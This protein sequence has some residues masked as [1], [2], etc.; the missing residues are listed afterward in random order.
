MADKS[1]TYRMGVDGKESVEAAFRD[2]ATTAETAMAKTAAAADAATAGVERLSSRQSRALDTLIG[3][4]SP[5]ENEAGKLERAL[6]LLAKG[7]AAGAISLEDQAR[8]AELAEQKWS[9]GAKAA[10]AEAAA[11]G[12]FRDALDPAAAELARLGAEQQK[13]NAWLADGKITAAEHAAGVAGLQAQMARLTAQTVA[14]NSDRPWWVDGNIMRNWVDVGQVLAASGGN[15][16]SALPAI[17]D[18][19]DVTAYY[20]GQSR[21]AA[22]G[23]G[24][25]GSAMA[26]AGDDAADAAV[27]LEELAAGTELAGRA[28]AGATARAG[29][30]AASLA[31]SVGGIAAAA[32]ILASLATVLIGGAAAWYVHTESLDDVDKALKRAGNTLGVTTS[33]LETMA[34]AAAAT[35]SISVGSAREM[36]Q[37][38]LATRAV[39][40]DAMSTLIG[41]SRD[42]GEVTGQNAAEAAA[43]LAKSF[44][45]PIGAAQRLD[46]QFGLLT[47]AE[48][49]QIRTL[50]DLGQRQQAQSQLADK[51]A[52]RIRGMHDDAVNPLTGA[53]ESLG[54]AAANAFDRIGAGIRKAAGGETLLEKI[55]R[56]TRELQ[57]AQGAVIAV[58]GFSADPTQLREQLADTLRVYHRQQESAGLEQWQNERVTAGKSIGDIVREASDVR[59]ALDDVDKK[60]VALNKQQIAIGVDQRTTAAIGVTRE[61][62]E[63]LRADLQAAEAAGKTMAQVQA[64]RTDAMY[65]KAAT[66]EAGARE[67]YIARESA[68]IG[69]LGSENTATERLTIARQAEN[70][71]LSDRTAA[72]TDASAASSREAGGVQAVADA[73]R[74]SEAAGLAWS[75]IQSKLA[76]AQGLHA[77]EAWA[78]G[79][80]QQDLSRRYAEAVAETASYIDGLQRQAAEEQALAAIAGQGAAAEAGVRAQ[81]EAQERTRSQLLALAA[82]EIVLRKELEKRQISQ[83]AYDAEVLAIEQQRADLAGQRKAIEDSLLSISLTQQLG[84]F[85]AQ[86]AEQ[87]QSLALTQAES[88]LLGVSEDERQRILTV[89][90]LQLDYE[91]WI[92]AAQGQQKA[93]LIAARD[94]AIALTNQYYAMKP[95][96]DAAKEAQQDW[97]A[98]ASSLKGEFA[99]LLTGLR[100][101]GVDALKD[102]ASD[103]QSILGDLQAKLT[104]NAVYSYLFSSGST[105]G[106]TGTAAATSASGGAAAAT[107]GDVSSISNLISGVSIGSALSGSTSSLGTKVATGLG[108]T[109]TLYF[110]DW[111]VGSTVTGLSDTGSF[112]ASGIDGASSLT[113]LVG[114]YLGSLASDLLFEFDSV[115]SQIGGTIGSTVG[116]VI[117]SAVL[118]SIPVVGTFLGAFAGDALGSWIGDL[119]ADQQSPAGG[120]GLYATASGS[121]G[122]SSIWGLD[123]VSGEDMAT[124]G[125]ALT[126]LLNSML[127]SMNAELA[128]P[129][130]SNFALGYDGDAGYY[131]S[132]DYVDRY[133][134]GSTAQTGYGSVEEAAIAMIQD[135]LGSG[136]AGDLDANVQ[137][138]LATIQTT[139]LTYYAEL[140]SLAAQWDDLLDILSTGTIDYQ[141]SLKQTADD[142]T[143]AYL[144]Q[145]KSFQDMASDAGLSLGDL[146]AAWEDAILRYIGLGEDGEEAMSDLE[147]GFWST[148][149]SIQDSA[150]LLQQVGYS[151]GQVTHVVGDA[152]TAMLEDF[153]TTFDQDNLT[154]L[155]D[156]QGK[157]Y[158]NDFADYIEAYQDASDY[159]ALIRSDGTSL[160]ALWS[161]T[162][163]SIIAG[164]DNAAVAVADLA[165][166]YPDYTDALWSAYDA[167]TATTY[168]LSQG[169]LYAQIKALDAGYAA[170]LD[171]MLYG[172]GVLPSALGG[173]LDTLQAAWSSLDGGAGDVAVLTG[174]VADLWDSAVDTGVL[175]VDDVE[176]IIGELIGLSQDYWQAQADLVESNAGL[177]SRA[178][179]AL[180]D[181]MAATM[182]DFDYAA[183]VERYSYLSAGGN[184][185]FYDALIGVE[186]LQSEL[187]VANDLAADQIALIE[188]DIAA[189]RSL[190]DTLRA[191]ADTAADLRTDSAL[192]IGTTY[193]KLQEAASQYQAALT[194]AN[195]NT[196][197]DDERDAAGQK[198]NDLSRTYLEWL[199]AYQGN[200]AAYVTGF[201]AVQ[202]DLTALSGTVADGLEAQTATLQDSIDVLTAIQ[203]SIDGQTAAQQMSA[204]DL[205]SLVAEKMDALTAAQASLSGLIGDFAS[206]VT[207]AVA[208]LYSGGSATTSGTGATWSDDW[209]NT[210]TSQSNAD[211]TITEIGADGAIWIHH[212]AGGL[213]GYDTGGLITNGVFGVDS[214]MAMTPSG[215]ALFGGGEYIMPSEQTALYYPILEAMR[216]G[217]FA[218]AYDAGGLLSGTVVPWRVNDDWPQTTSRLGDEMLAVVAREAQSQTRL[219]RELLS[220]V[221][222]G[223]ARLEARLDAMLEQLS[224]L[225]AQGGLTAAMPGRKRR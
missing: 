174:L 51:L 39:G 101:D 158:L 166:A 107:S 225:A 191:L 217:D 14:A 181:D 23:A 93:D 71:V 214:V 70:R 111:G 187:S 194:A 87:K 165:A 53:F 50:T 201:N 204:E 95:A 102:F 199:Q 6:D 219:L 9:A 155:Y 106:A 209:G 213:I 46:A 159:A 175:A 92:A 7:A 156:L 169:S 38:Y 122:V 202:S 162:V 40:A 68:L 82:R 54:T 197:S 179:A 62:L 173:V 4:L 19:A 164:A 25:M 59:G 3:R 171:D 168:A 30:L 157:S 118:S 140:V 10:A 150:Q 167:V 134:L 160:Q 20:Y 192:G 1:V 115:E 90:R 26:A 138:A 218:G 132:G 61:R 154:A 5:A 18:A 206:S 55:V 176:S 180:G 200:T 8:Y 83:S 21:K 74:Q 42:W 177:L 152:L 216:R 69:L 133:N 205:Q 136:Y 198:L 123:G 203:D 186:R 161:A 220:A 109:D 78:L 44:S 119:F 75:V 104:V 189:K 88:A 77:G 27:S 185:Q 84:A 86:I 37:A 113:G 96:L 100:S 193:T 47:D 56:L 142:T 16:A 15:I 188:D 24:E 2:I 126:E 52:D 153:Q 17:L 182:A 64:E 141:D 89:T 131:Y 12:A 29:G 212:D 43:D 190:I 148:V 184:A 94:E 63:A 32:G 45:D 222:N 110:D 72:I 28:A 172:V 151:Y 143:D 137:T 178:Y 210:W 41:L 85:R 223:D 114:S 66:M 35:G 221:V 130:G 65:A 105:T 103:A 170:S 13:V 127:T 22:N 81:L 196:L 147:Q 117:G 207:S 108:L 183:A 211:G 97:A 128:L 129:A 57:D 34:A 49:V 121:A 112:L 163:E 76:E 215:P 124:A 48:L 98:A 31:G 145:I 67:Q 60:L 33:D 79:Q 36:Q 73:Y 99:D 80:A 195:D 149:Y 11:I 120:I 208:S 116:S 58:P 224:D 125:D 139:D 146:N 91:R 135:I 144:E